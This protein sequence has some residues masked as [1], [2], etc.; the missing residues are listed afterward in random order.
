M[1]PSAHLCY[2]LCTYL[3][4]IAVNVCKVYLAHYMVTQITHFSSHRMHLIEW[5]EIYLNLNL[6]KKMR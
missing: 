4:P 3:V 2:A 1:L 5:D 6:N